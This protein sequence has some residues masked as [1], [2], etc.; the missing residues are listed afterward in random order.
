MVALVPFGGRI[1]MLG[2]GSVGQSVVPVLER[3][4]DLPLSNITIIEADDHADKFA[5]FA[6][7]GM[8]YVRL[9]LTP[10]NLTASLGSYLKAGD[11]C[12]NLTAGVDA[13][14]IIDWCHHNGVLYVD[15][16][17]EPW[18]DQYGEEGIPAAKRTHYESHE[19]MRAMAAPWGGKG[20]TAVITHG[21]NP[22][23]VN[24][25]VKA[26]TLDIAQAMNL[27]FSTPKSREDWADLFMRTGTKVIHVS[28][29]DTQRSSIPKEPDEFVNTWSVLG[30]WGEAT[31][32]AEMGW[33][34]HENMLP[35]M[36][37]HFTHGPGN[38]IYMHKPGGLTLVR[39]WVP[40][41]GPIFG[42]VISH[43]ESITL[44]HYFT[45]YDQDNRPVHRPTVHYAYHPSAD[46]IVSLREVMMKDWQPPAKVRIMQDDIVDGIDE[47]GVLLL[48]H[49]KTAWWYGSQL[50]IHE[51]RKIIPG[52]NATA[53]QVCAGVISACVW[54]VKNPDRG[55]CEP[56]YLP[57]AEILEIAK[58]YL[59]PVASVQSDWTPLRDRAG[60]NF[61]PWVDHQDPWQFNN[62]LVR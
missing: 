14:S 30:Y 37:Q 10:E 5:P 4:F 28:E 3:H 54:A 59:G 6:A 8:N 19:R 11:L 40:K 12:I 55:F 17:L 42:F 57:H 29:R 44:S 13:L 56:E 16:S 39:S 24:H 62:F 22:G 41:G 36:G 51:A 23:I 1:V 48:G 7:K 53:L 35:P 34:M 9:S 52:Q 60:L 49:G 47:L 2:Y 43:S 25:F 61:E 50:S 21:A 58:P 38:A 26:A 20:P 33:G 46:A 27:D 31:Y 18:A 15:T 45:A 32:P